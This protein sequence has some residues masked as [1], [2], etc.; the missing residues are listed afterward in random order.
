MNIALIAQLIAAGLA[1]APELLKAAAMFKEFIANLFSHTL[2][3][4]EDQDKLFNYVDTAVAAF[5]DG[6]TPPHWEVEPDPE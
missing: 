3:T 2:I 5:Q 4:K 6:Q 1:A